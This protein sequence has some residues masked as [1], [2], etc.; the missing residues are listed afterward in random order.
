[1]FGLRRPDRTLH[2]AIARRLVLGFLMAL[3]AIAAGWM[4]VPPDVGVDKATQE[5]YTR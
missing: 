4:L 1:M 5:W 2:Q 3:F